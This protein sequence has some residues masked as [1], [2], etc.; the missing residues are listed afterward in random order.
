MLESGARSVRQP[1]SGFS[2]QGVNTCFV[3]TGMSELTYMTHVYIKK[4]FLYTPKIKHCTVVLVI[5]LLNLNCLK[6]IF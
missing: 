6:K 1:V 5:E 4:N 3:Y 2:I